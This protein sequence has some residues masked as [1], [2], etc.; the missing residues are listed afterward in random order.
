MENLAGILMDENLPS[1][2]LPLVGAGLISLDKSFEIQVA[3]QNYDLNFIEYLVKYSIID[4]I[5][6]A[7]C[8]AEYF[9]F[10][11]LYL[12]AQDIS[13]EISGLL[14]TDFIDKHKV[15][16]LRLDAEILYLA[17]DDPSQYSVITEVKFHTGF[18][19]I[20]IVVEHDKLL[21]QIR[22]LLHLR[23][24]SS[25]GL[26]HKVAENINDDPCVKYVNNILHKALQKKSSDIH[27]EP[28]AEYYR[29]RLR[30]DG[31]LHTFTHSENIIASQLCARIKVLA[32]LNIVE[33]RLPQDGRF[34]FNGINSQTVDCRV[35][36]CPTV[37]GEKIVIRFLNLV[38]SDSLSIESLNMPNRDNSEFIKALL[39]PQGLI[40]VT[41][42]TG[43]GKSTTLY[44][45]LNYLN[46]STLNIVSVEDPVEIKLAG[47][48]QVQVSRNLSFAKVLRAILRQDPDIIMLGEIRD[49]ETAQIA[50]QAA[51]TGH[52]VL[53]SIHTNSAAQTVS[54]LINIG[55]Q[56]YNLVD[57]LR[58]I[59]AQRLLRKLCREC[60]LPV[61]NKIYKASSGCRQC[62]GGYKGRVAIF[63]VMPIT[64]KI[65]NYFANVSM[66]TNSLE[67]LAIQ[68]GMQLIKSAGLQQVHAGNTSYEEL[69]RVCEI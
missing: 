11:Y 57:S 47:V 1:V 52:L 21:E 9:N 8:L 44:T 20:P 25:I 55:V 46:K 65:N 42:P 26:E 51:Q 28:S 59:I 13:S 45:A 30:I 4:S 2:A 29:I 50:V 24:I 60:R 34:T 7:K 32:N 35:S 27:F 33:R 53:A 17:M 40:L 61:E 18:E 63:E 64:E 66:Q 5:K 36:I 3:A 62:N 56:V 68:S 6:I 22:K 49:L 67:S 39:S 48:N 10:Q 23:T 54:R 16:P 31:I 41:G 19:V 14:S 37:V 43:S 69:Q 38:D 12:R 15:L 58:M